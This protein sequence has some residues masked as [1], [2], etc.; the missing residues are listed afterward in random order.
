MKRTVLPP[1]SR[2]DMRQDSYWRAAKKGLTMK[3]FRRLQQKTEMRKVV[4]AALRGDTTKLMG[5]GYSSSDAKRLI[6]IA[7]KA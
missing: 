2:S 6:T 4:R 5:L 1:A 7:Q 3:E